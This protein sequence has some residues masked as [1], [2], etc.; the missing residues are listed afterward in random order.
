MTTWVWLSAHHSFTLSR[1]TCRW[2]SSSRASGSIST[3]PD[4]AT[5]EAARWTW[6]SS[7]RATGGVRR[8]GG[9]EVEGELAA[10]QVSGTS[11]PAGVERRLGAEHP[12]R[13]DAESCRVVEVEGVGQVELGL[14]PHR[15]RV[16]DVLV[17]DRDACRAPPGAG[18]SG[19]GAGTA[20]PD[21]NAR[22]LIDARERSAIAE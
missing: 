7:R 5:A 11:A 3:S 6:R 17:V 16:G 13:L 21:R 8:L 4:S 22:S 10:D 9:A 18:S 14:D 1:R 20:G 12:E 15:S 2:P 19:C